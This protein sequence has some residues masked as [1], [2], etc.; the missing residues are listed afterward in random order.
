[1]QRSLLLGAFL[2]F[3]AGLATASGSWIQVSGGSWVVP[4]HLIAQLDKSLQ[5]AA[6]DSQANKSSPKSL[7]LYVKQY[8]GRDG[9]NG[10]EVE[11]RGFCQ[12][13]GRSRKDLMEDFIH[14]LDGGDCYFQATWD[15]NTSRFKQFHF[16][17]VA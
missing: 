14:V 1:M 7:S 17:G 12:T 13:S 15:V 5:A 6:K 9:R 10:R 2:A 16:N 11:V 8:R 3:F 4:A